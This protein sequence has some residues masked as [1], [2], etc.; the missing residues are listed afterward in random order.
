MPSGKEGFEG[1]D[2]DLGELPE[3]KPAV[4]SFLQGHQKLWMEEGEE[5]PPEPTVLD[6]A[7]WVHWK[8]ERCDTPSWWM[9]LSTVQEKIIPGS[10]PGRLEHPSDY[11]GDYRN[12]MQ[13]GVLFRLP[14]L[15]HAF[16]SK[17]L[18]CQLIQSLPVGT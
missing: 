10:L 16:I 1:R 11:H 7:E 4:A 5:M 13:K 17:D 9:E 6:F 3:L 15:C 14:M 18:C 2:S 12:W 8:A